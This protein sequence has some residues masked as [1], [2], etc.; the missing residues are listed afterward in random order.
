VT[1]ANLHT[2]SEEMI[3]L[4]IVNQRLLNDENSKESRDIMDLPS[5]RFSC[6]STKP[7]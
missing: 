3:I 1:L 5:E 7:L 4:F 2:T 6:P